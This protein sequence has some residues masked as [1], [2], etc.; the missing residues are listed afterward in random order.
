MHFSLLGL[1]SL[2]SVFN[3]FFVEEMKEWLIQNNP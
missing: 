3:I 1:D 2:S